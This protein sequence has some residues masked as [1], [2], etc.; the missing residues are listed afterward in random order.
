MNVNPNFRFLLFFI[1]CFAAN[2]YAQ[3]GKNLDYTTGGTEV[4]NTYTSLTANS[5][6]GATSITV[7]NN[8][9][10]GGAFGATPLQPGDLILIIQMQGATIN[11]ETYT[12]N[13]G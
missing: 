6:V 5:A 13:A 12:S 4:L 10:T 9:L 11:C 7:A 3:R 2:S 1:I 8:A